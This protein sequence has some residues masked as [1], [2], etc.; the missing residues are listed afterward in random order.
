MPLFNGIVTSQGMSIP[1]LLTLADMGIPLKAPWGTDC[2][3]CPRGPT[4]WVKGGAQESV[5]NSFSIEVDVAGP[6][7]TLWKPMYKMILNV[8]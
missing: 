8:I 6:G 1:V 4:S 3:P 2:C 5:S 7:T